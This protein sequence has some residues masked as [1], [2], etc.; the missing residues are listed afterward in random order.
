MLELE[1][2]RGVMRSIIALDM[3]AQR[4]A[5]S[6]VPW[7]IVIGK[8]AQATLRACVHVAAVRSA[9]YC[10]STMKPDTG[11]TELQALTDEAQTAAGA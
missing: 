11:Y 8:P 2:V 5:L 1:Q 4:R 6:A 9:A 10:W 3:P 7:M